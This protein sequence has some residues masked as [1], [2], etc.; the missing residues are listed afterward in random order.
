MR[1]LLI[2]LLRQV[3]LVS[4]FLF[5][6]CFFNQ[7]FAG[8]FGAGVMLG[9]PTGLTGKI[10]LPRNRAVDLALAWRTSHPEAFHFH[11]DYLWESENVF[12]SKQLPLDVHYGVGGRLLIFDD[13]GHHHHHDD[14]L[15]VGVRFPLGLDYK[16][17][18]PRFEFFAE[19]ALVVEVIPDTEADFDFGLGFRYYF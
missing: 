1:Q 7:S 3:R 10:L 18:H 19:I 16:L 17:S 15:G 14:D 12:R 5:V 6:L 11:S 13:D 2:K 8:N 9:D 4:L